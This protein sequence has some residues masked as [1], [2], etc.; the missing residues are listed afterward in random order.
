MMVDKSYCYLC[1]LS[2]CEN[3]CD[4]GNDECDGKCV[5]HRISC[6]GEDEFCNNGWIDIYSDDSDDDG[7]EQKHVCNICAKG[8]RLEEFRTKCR[9]ESTA[10]IRNLIRK[11]TKKTWQEF[12][13]NPG[14]E[15]RF[16]IQRKNVKNTL[17]NYGLHGAIMGL[18]LNTVK[19]LIKHGANDFDEAIRVC[20]NRNLPE[21]FIFLFCRMKSFS[22]N[23]ENFFKWWMLPNQ[24]IYGLFDRKIKLKCPTKEDKMWKKE[25][26][27]I[28]KC[29]RK[30][31]ELLLFAFFPRYFIKTIILPCVSHCYNF[32]FRD[33]QIK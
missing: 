8:E 5:Q 29:N 2:D 12:G 21:S 28:Y 26:V 20:V 24:I 15:K 17:W 3:E 19:L 18:N 6:S 31:A 13:L 16:L 11:K 14:H 22:L 7:D 32:N 10:F 23:G 1:G 25:S 9:T 27:K 4:C 30:K 33:Y